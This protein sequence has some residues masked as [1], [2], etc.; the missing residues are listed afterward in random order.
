VTGTSSEKGKKTNRGRVV[1]RSHRREGTAAIGSGN[2][3]VENCRALGGWAAQSTLN[4]YQGRR[5]QGHEEEV[6]APLASERGGAGGLE[7]K[8]K[9]IALSRVS[10]E[11]QERRWGSV[12]FWPDKGEGGR[13][14]N[15]RHQRRGGSTLRSGWALWGGRD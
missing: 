5:G 2:R 14:L 4:T 11:E 12:F 9:S 15:V 7:G 6:V 13:T 10:R 8:G 1:F 3:S